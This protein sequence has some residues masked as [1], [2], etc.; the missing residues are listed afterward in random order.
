LTQVLERTPNEIGP[1]ENGPTDPA[2]ARR[3]PA[4]RPRVHRPD[5]EGL[6]ALAVGAIVLYDAQ[7][8][9]RGGYVGIDVFFVISGFLLTRQLLANGAQEPTELVRW[10]ARRI[11][12][13]LPPLAA[14]A[15]VTLTAAALWASAGQLRATGTDTG[16]AAIFGLNEHLAGDGARYLDHGHVVSLVQ[17]LWPID[18]AAQAFLG[19]PLVVFAISFLFRRLRRLA[20]AVVL[21]AVI[22]VSYRWSM[23]DTVQSPAHAYFS[24]PT[25][26]WE[27]AVGALVA[28]VAG[29]LV[30]LPRLI[31]ELA[32]ALGLIAV[33]G[34][35]FAFSDATR[36]PG[37]VAALPVAGAALVIGCGLPARRRVERLL[38]ESLLQCLGRT[39]YSWYLWHWP[40]LIMV[41]I[42]VGHS[43]QWPGRVA[44]VWV[45]LLVAIVSYFATENL[46]RGVR[47]PDVS[48]FGIGALLTAVV[49]AA[50][51]A[52]LVNPAS[53]APTPVAAS[54]SRASDPV[55]GNPYLAQVEA[56]VSAAAGAKP[57]PVNLTPSLTRAAGDVPDPAAQGCHLDYLTVAQGDCVFGD[58][59]GTRTAVLFGDS[60][61]EQWEPA[62]AIAGAQAHWKIVSWTKAGCPVAGVSVWAAALGR[63]YAECDAWRQQTIARIA[64]LKPSLIVVSESE[65]AQG[66]TP[67]TAKAWAAGTVAT[68]DTLRTQSG[69]PVVVVG[70]T[71]TPAT[72]VPACVATH[73]TD[74]GACSTATAHA[75]AYPDRRPALTSAVT[76]AGFELVDPQA[77]LCTPAVCPPT[78][79]SYLV[80]RDATHLS[81][82]YVEYLTPLIAPLLKA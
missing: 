9:V 32:A 34:S 51:C 49:A 76:R 70:D 15:I 58:P 77:W 37:S 38:G 45:S 1:T 56:A 5:I 3:S 29:G 35:C 48:W 69:A 25:R 26:A 22:A 71:P 68:L 28:V 33:I 82:E 30:R 23:L 67:I 21:V 60:A 39:S 2:S 75:Y 16:Y 4:P 55:A 46:S 19:W 10:Y 24:L 40:I 18:V 81:V 12:R 78:V 63:T 61:M 59:N 57:V 11:R 17:Q 66:L 8:G 41:P 6:R 72:A 7:L 36:Y 65:N 27:I 13:V 47:L 43:L 80:Y 73:L 14:V 20:L 50:G 52:V 44:L 74:V 53:I 31:A 64:A 62:F 79:G 54:S 42:V